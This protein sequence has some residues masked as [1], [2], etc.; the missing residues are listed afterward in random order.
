[1]ILTPSG[2][3]ERWLERA[4][5]A[6]ARPFDLVGRRRPA[7]V[8]SLPEV[9]RPDLSVEVRR[10]LVTG[11]SGRVGTLL[12]PWLRRTGLELACVDRRGGPGVPGD[13]P[14]Q[15]AE[16]REAVTVDRLVRGHDAIVHLAAVPSEASV[17]ALWPDN[18]LALAHLLEAAVRHGVGRFV[19][20]SS[21]HVLGLY[22]RDER[23]DESSAP[24]PD[25]HYAASKL[26]G[27]ALCRF[28]AEHHGLAV[29]CLR[30][31][32]VAA[33]LEDAEPA[34]WIAPG[35]VAQ[36]VEIAFRRDRPGFE[37]FHAVADYPGSP[38]APSRAGAFGYRCREVAEP[39]E[40][41]LARVAR[42]WRD[43][44][45]ARRKRGASFASGR[46]RS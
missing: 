1:M 10:A 14:V 3:V 24:R 15:R 45:V 26:H 12:L 42:T 9:R 39:W 25:G 7:P 5:R 13:G 27:E 33:T 29:T 17:E 20:A 23:I 36:M 37:L 11:A 34:N 22:D 30:L 40:A 31:G 43:D 41:A 28:Y 38:L 32:H 2:R 35:D 6:A 8:R 46:S 4:Q 19:F 18:T 21:M 44:P 16:L